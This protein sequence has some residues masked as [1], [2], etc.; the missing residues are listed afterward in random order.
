[1][2]ESSLKQARFKEWSVADL[3]GDEN[4]GQ[5][6]SD[7]EEES[8]T[9]QGVAE[10]E[11]RQTREKAKYLS[12][13]ANGNELAMIHLGTINEDEDEESEKSEKSFD[14]EAEIQEK[15]KKEIDVKRNE[16]SKA[17]K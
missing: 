10:F 1:M 5:V 14:N 2:E 6:Y 9:I 12:K 4:E 15:R 8:K 17:R 3:V 13:V 16:A 7:D 11:N